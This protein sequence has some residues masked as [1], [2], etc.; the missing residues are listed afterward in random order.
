VGA[1]PIADGMASRTGGRNRPACPQLFHAALQSCELPSE[2]SAAE[3]P[4][5]SSRRFLQLVA[6]VAE[7]DEQHGELVLQ[8]TA[9]AGRVGHG[10][11]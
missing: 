4:E 5:Q 6:E 1:Q 9:V 2:P 8:A 3:V 11:G 7:L 10:A